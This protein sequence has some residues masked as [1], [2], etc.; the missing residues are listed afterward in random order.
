MPSLHAVAVLVITGAVFYLYTRPWIRMEAV[1]LLLLT[2][3]LVTFHLFPYVGGE[4]RLSD[5]EILQAFGHPALIAICSLMILGRGLTMTGAMEPAVRALGRI[6]SWSA[7]V[8]LLLTLAIAGLA[9]GFVNDTPVLVLM[10]PML[11]GIADRTGHSAA[12]TLMP[13][14]YAIL[15]GGMLTSIGT[16]TNLLVL[17]IANDLGMPAMGI[18]DFTPIAAASFAVAL[19]YLWL[20]APR[21]LPDRAPATPENLRQFEARLVVDAD[22]ERLAGK[23]LDELAKAL[24]RP[25]PLTSLLRGGR[26]A[27]AAGDVTLAAGDAL[28]LRDTAR[29]LSEVA[30][31]YHAD[32]FDREGEGRFAAGDDSAVEGDIGLVE[33]VVGVDS[34]LVGRSLRSVRFAETH[35]V[36]VVGLNRGAEGLLRRFDDLARTRLAVGDVLLVQGTTERLAELAKVEHL[37]LLDGRVTLPRSPLAP[38]A[39][40]IMGGVIVL[41]ATK[42][43]PI[44]VAAFAGVIAMLAAGCV[45]LD[46]L[47]RALSM[48]VVLLV[49]SSIALG[50]SLVDTGAAAWIAQGVAVAVQQVAPALRLVVFM[51]FGALLTNFVSNTAAAAVGTP[52]AVATALE[53]GSPMEPY[54]LSILFGANL[55]YATPMAYQTNVLVMNAA[56]YRFVDFVRVGTPLVL[57]M[58]ATLSLLLVNAYDLR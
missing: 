8:G 56:N 11:L 17:S 34:H 54:V 30:T 38:W 13:V 48:E 29:G 22:N 23:S 10:L 4:R 41:A 27:A 31:T 18:F 35:K 21:L 39:L 32:L 20:V 36:V 51:A 7:S 16:S 1:S 37:M 15:A 58:L 2:A 44:H 50:Q 19:P 53:L 12:R 26:K 52:I 9:S 3:L 14:N 55:S 6:W 47:G 49:A 40:A 42:T 43:L 28:L 57:L 45:K 24:G 25:L 33:A 5:A 46:G